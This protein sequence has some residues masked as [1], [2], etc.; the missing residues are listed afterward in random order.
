[1]PARQAVGLESLDPALLALVLLAAGL[2]ASWNASAKSSRDPLLAIAALTASGGLVIGPLI[3]F[4]PAPAPASWPFLAASVALHFAYQLFLV[5]SYSLGDLSQVYP[6][7]RGAAPAFAAALAAWAASEIPSLRQCLG[8][9]ITSGALFFLG[10]RGAGGLS[11]GPAVRSALVTALLISAYTVVDGLG[12]RRAGDPFS[13]IVWMALLDAFPILAVGLWVRRG[14]TV[15]FLRNEGWRAAAGG[16][17]AMLGYAIVLWVMSQ[18]AIAVVAALRE[19]SVVFAALLGWLLLGEPF[20]RRRVLA[21]VAL[22][23]GLVLVQL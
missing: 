5:R 23:A 1:M 10:S 16:I 15:E 14:R 7:A 3:F 17:V 13:Y 2:H 21:S 4:L 8:L 6:I 11:S 18:G 22:V 9:A 12:V 19:T 20:G